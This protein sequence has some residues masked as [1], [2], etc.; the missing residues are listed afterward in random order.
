M[1]RL[2]SPNRHVL[3]SKLVLLVQPEM[4]WY[5]PNVIWQ[6]VVALAILRYTTKTTNPMCIGCFCCSSGLNVC[7]R[8][9]YRLRLV[10]N[11]YYYTCHFRDPLCE[12]ILVR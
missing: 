3:G 8:H 4:V 11:Y 6:S 1:E 7:L 5:L 10:D 9:N 2:C 12:Y